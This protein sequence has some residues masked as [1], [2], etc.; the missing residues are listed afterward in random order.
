M[1]KG[2][3]VVLA[4]AAVLALCVGCAGTPG[5]DGTEGDE[6]PKPAPKVVKKTGE[7]TA[8]QIDQIVTNFGGIDRKHA[9]AVWK[10]KEAQEQAADEFA[11]YLIIRKDGDD[12]QEFLK[13]AIKTHRKAKALVVPL[14]ELYP[15]NNAINHMANV[16]IMGLRALETA[17]KE[18]QSPESK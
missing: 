4:S 6:A 11:A 15:H 13:V 16:V 10:A 17:T 14:C 9:V 18:T 7:P 8:E 5:K 3:V 2:F 12:N 1:R